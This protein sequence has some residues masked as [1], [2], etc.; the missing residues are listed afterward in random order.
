MVA[1]AEELLPRQ[2]RSAPQIGARTPAMSSTAGPIVS[3][4]PSACSMTVS[5]S[6]TSA[7]SIGSRERSLRAATGTGRFQPR[8]VPWLTAHQRLTWDYEHRPEHAKAWVRWPM[9]GLMSHTGGPPPLAVG[10]FRHALSAV[11]WAARCL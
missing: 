7:I 4:W 2:D 5:R 11:D 10:T 6:G 1:D 8:G 3:W 9:I